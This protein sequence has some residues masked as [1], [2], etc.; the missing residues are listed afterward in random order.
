MMTRSKRG[1]TLLELLVSLAIILILVALLLPAAERVRDLARRLNC[2]SNQRGM[3]IS[4]IQFSLDYND[5]APRGMDTWHQ[6]G[7]SS[8]DLAPYE[9]YLRYSTASPQFTSHLSYAYGNLEVNSWYRDNQP[10]NKIRIMPM[11]SLAVLKY[12]NDVE[13]LYCP[14]QYHSSWGA[15]TSGYCLGFI[16]MNKTG[17]GYWRNLVDGDHNYWYSNGKCHPKIGYGH[18]FY[19]LE[20]GSDASVRNNNRTPDDPFKDRGAVRNLTMGGIASNY[21]RDGWS[22]MIFSCINDRYTQ[23]HPEQA[24]SGRRTGMN[25]AF[26]DGSVRWID[27]LEVERLAA[28]YNPSWLAEGTNHLFFNGIYDSGKSK[29]RLEYLARNGMRLTSGR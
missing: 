15:P 5:R 2:T 9:P 21:K 7:G 14:D 11:G 19:V 13:R 23:S 10:G 16:Q 6:G 17:K 4:A 18:Y 28:A 22:P 8:Y 29:G 27:P 20:S 26:F 1:F 25:G 3:A 24:P 12:F